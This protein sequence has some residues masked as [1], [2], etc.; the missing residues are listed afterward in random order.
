MNNFY[1]L[2]L[3]LPWCL[4]SIS[5]RIK[6]KEIDL[7]NHYSFQIIERQQPGL[8][9]PKGGFLLLATHIMVSKGFVYGWMDGTEGLCFIL[10]TDNGEIR[11]NI[12]IKE[13]HAI[14]EKNGIPEYNMS[15]SVTYWDI[16]TGYKMKNW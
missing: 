1:L 3:I 14:T 10:N 9:D 7:P 11:K 12:H 4:V 2:I 6:E 15:S 13:L 8:V 5:C 16:T